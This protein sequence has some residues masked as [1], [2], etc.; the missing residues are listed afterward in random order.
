[1]LPEGV[2]PFAVQPASGDQR[3][4][5]PGI[6]APVQPKLG[7]IA[8]IGRILAA[9]ELQ[10]VEARGA[11]GG[12]QLSLLH[13]TGR[14]PGEREPHV[15]IPCSN[16]ISRPSAAERYAKSRRATVIKLS[17]PLLGGSTPFSIA[18][19]RWSRPTNTDSGFLVPA[20]GLGQRSAGV[21]AA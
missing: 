5:C 10:A 21:R 15:D 9:L 20:N 13:G 2:N 12:E 6:S 8:K 18:V 3:R 7:R 1:H 11:V 17:R 16:R 19:S 4:G 14:R